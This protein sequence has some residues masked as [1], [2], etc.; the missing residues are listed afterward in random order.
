[1]HKDL[2]SAEKRNLPDPSSL[3]LVVVMN[4]LRDMEIARLLGWYRIP[5]R[6]APKV[7]A[8]DYL[9]FYQTSVFGERKWQI[10]YIAQVRGHELVSRGELFNEELDHPRAKQLY[11]KIQLGPL[12]QLAQPIMATNWRRI[13]FF[14]SVGEL[15]N[16][17]ATLNDLVVPSEERQLIW[18]A[19]RDRSLHPDLY[20]P[21]PSEEKTDELPI[22]PSLLQALFE[23]RKYT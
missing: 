17:A 7:I 4:Q 18:Q 15:F 10:E 5:M 13:T 1:M 3:I 12:T 21:A 8:V 16:R 20:Q 9:A 11:Y 6:S 23:F 19:L 2:S 14:Y 22:D